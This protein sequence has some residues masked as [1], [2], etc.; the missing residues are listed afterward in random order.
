MISPSFKALLFTAPLLLLA[1][2][3]A[4]TATPENE[5]FQQGPWTGH[6]VSEADNDQPQ[7]CTVTRTSP[8]GSVTLTF[9]RRIGG[10]AGL[11]VEFE[12]ERANDLGNFAIYVDG[13]FIRGPASYSEDEGVVEKQFLGYGNEVTQAILRRFRTGKEVTFDPAGADLPP[14]RLDGADEALGRLNDCKSWSP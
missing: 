9:I 1:T 11:R 3:E 10:N 13:D 5:V 7:Q 4:Q 14:V 2:A 6:V 8:E 12:P